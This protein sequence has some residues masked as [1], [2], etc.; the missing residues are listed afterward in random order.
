MTDPLT[1]AQLA[2]IAAREKGRMRENMA[3]HPMIENVRM[4]IEDHHSCDRAVTQH[5]ARAAI[6]AVLAGLSEPSDAATDRAYN[7][8]AFNDQ[9][10]IQDDGD[11]KKA[12]AAMLAQAKTDILGAETQEKG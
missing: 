12:V 3:D 6:A 4:A 5:V 2:E 11:F 8:V 1:D 7:A 10:H 9:W